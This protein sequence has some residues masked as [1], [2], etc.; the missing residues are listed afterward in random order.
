[1]SRYLGGVSLEGG[2]ST[3]ATFLH[4]FILCISRHPQV[5]ARAQKDIDAIIGQDRMP[6]MDDL[7]QLPF[8]EAII[9]EVWN[10]SHVSISDPHSLSLLCTGSRSTYIPGT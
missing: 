6:Q 10:Y 7:T 3:T 4:R 8:V 5:Q 9:K 1:M 2:A